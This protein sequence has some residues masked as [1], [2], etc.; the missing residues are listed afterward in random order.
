MPEEAFVD[1]PFQYV[2]TLLCVQ[3]KESRCLFDGW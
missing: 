2:A 1:E 3:L